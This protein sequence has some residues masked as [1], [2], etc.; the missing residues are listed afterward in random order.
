MR[1]RNVNNFFWKKIDV[2]IGK[3]LNLALSREIVGGGQGFCDNK[4]SVINSVTMGEGGHKMSKI[5]C[6]LWMTLLA[7]A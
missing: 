1:V 7:E 5:A 3:K 6:R 4:A 2:Q